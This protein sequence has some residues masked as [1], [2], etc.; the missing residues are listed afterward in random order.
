VDN[1]TGTSALIEM[2]RAY[3]QLPTPPDR[4]ILFLAVTAEEQGLLG[5]R[6]Y[7]ENPLYPLERTLAV[8]NMDAFMPLGRTEDVIVI[9][10]GSSSLE[11]VLERHAAA[12][13][14]WSSPT[15]SRR[16]GSSTGPTT[17]SSPSRASRP[18]TSIRA[19][20]CGTGPKAGGWK[21]DEFTVNDYHK[22]R[23]R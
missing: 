14:R 11:D 7:A 6:H 3:T 10:R 23:T 5:A 19:R 15:P 9:G 1:A 4:S 17:S 13:G 16:R 2:A 12:Q 20:G 21:R 8:I 22:P 18:S